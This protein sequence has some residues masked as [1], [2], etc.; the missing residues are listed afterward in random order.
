LL[1]S[2]QLCAKEV[3]IFASE[4]CTLAACKAAG[5]CFNWFLLWT[6]HLFHGTWKIRLSSI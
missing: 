2:N 3:Q 6:R 1:G 4:T 5:S